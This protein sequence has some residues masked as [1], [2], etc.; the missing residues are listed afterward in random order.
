M[1]NS[2]EKVAGFLDI[3]NCIAKV[4]IFEFGELDLIIDRCQLTVSREKR[5]VLSLVLVCN[6]FKTDQEREKAILDVLAGKSNPESNG[7]KV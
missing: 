6:S 5:R 2:K 7:F 1:K 4:R 3:V